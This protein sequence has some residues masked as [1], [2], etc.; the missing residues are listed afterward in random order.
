MLREHALCLLWEPKPQVPL[1]P[2]KRCTQKIH[3]AL[4]L[5][6]PRPYMWLTCRATLEGSRAQLGHMKLLTF[7]FANGKIF[8]PKVT[9]QG[10]F[11][12]FPKQVR[13]QDVKRYSSRS[14]I[15]CSEC[16][17]V[18]PLTKLQEQ[19]LQ[20]IDVKQMDKYQLIP[21]R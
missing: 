11:N 12:S 20:I 17:R 13:I 15:G 10:D 3:L 4:A 9:N 16:C 18:K 2:R 7:S 1:K 6:R 8:H 14:K 19:A 5:K 21:K